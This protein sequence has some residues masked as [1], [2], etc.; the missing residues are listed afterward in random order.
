MALKR[1]GVSPDQ[2][3][4]SDPRLAALIAQGAT[5]EEFEGIARE[6]IGNRISKPVPWVLVTLQNRREEAAA[7]TLP[8]AQQAT[9]SA[10]AKAVADTQQYLANLAEETSRARESYAAK[11]AQGAAT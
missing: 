9:P 8:P 5:P 4:L 2:I 1:A 3:N 6:A 10:P 7:I 11:K